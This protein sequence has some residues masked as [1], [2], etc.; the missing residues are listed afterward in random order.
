MR[1]GI[2]NP[3]CIILRM[4]IIVRQA[5]V[6]LCVAVAGFVPAVA[7]AQAQLV[8][9][10]DAARGAQLFEQGNAA[11]GVVACS[12]CHGPGG[13]ST[14]PAN[15]NLAGLPREYLVKQ[16]TEFKAGADGKPPL[17]QGP[18]GAPTVMTA[19]VETLTAQ[20]AQDIALYLSTQPLKEPANATA[21]D[22]NQEAGLGRRIWRAGLADRGVP[23]CAS[24]HG[25]AGAGVPARYPRLSGQFPSYIEMQ[26]K[27]FRS[28]DRGS[29]QPMHDIAGR[30]SDADIG[31]VAD[32]AAG[33]R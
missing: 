29:G 14:I 22:K 17:R 28:G 21:G 3:D 32:Y 18:D 19:M 26:L 12:S 27:L 6:A 24:C 8:S 25:A 15:P 10:P 20:D 5:V 23:A 16:I 2:R 11:R 31:A 7:P 9:W 13:G 1:G 30:M 33:L 4:S